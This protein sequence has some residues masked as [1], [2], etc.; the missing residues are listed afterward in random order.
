MRAYH[1]RLKPGATPPPPK[2]GAVREPHPVQKPSKALIAT[3]A[4]VL[5]IM[6]LGAITWFQPWEHRRNAGGVALNPSIAVLP[7][8]NVSDDPAQE[9]YA[10]G[11]TSDLITDLSKLSGLAVIA[12]HSVFAY[13]NTPT[14][15]DRIA[16]ELGVRYVL[17]GSVR[18]FDDQIRINASLIDSETAQSIWS[19]RYDGDESELFDLHNRV[20]ENIVSALAVELTD[21]ERTL[22]EQPPTRNLE[23]YDYY[24]RA[25]QRRLS[26]ATYHTW[27]SIAVEAIDFY[28]K[29]IALDPEFAEPHA[30]LALLAL[31]IWGADS[32]DYH[33]RCHGAQTGL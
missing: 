19:E 10:D 27:A 28:R 32:S 33:A 31:D 20:I 6:V 26:G 3:A 29:A 30:G 9:F 21:Q 16:T 11:M 12:R 1:A 17:E 13:K 24:Q 5:A 25:E 14:P 15:L 2:L 23:A 18:R 7:F 4:V 22:F 8:E